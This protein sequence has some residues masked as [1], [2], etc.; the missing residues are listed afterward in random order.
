MGGWPRHH[1]DQYA[2]RAHG[3]SGRYRARPAA[4]HGARIPPGRALSAFRPVAAG[5]LSPEQG[6]LARPHGRARRYGPHRAGDRAPARRHARA[7][8]LS[9]APACSGHSLPALSEPV[10][11]GAAGGSPA[12]HYAGR[13]ADQKSHQ[14]RGARCAGQTRHPH[15]HGPRVSGGRAGADQGA[16]GRGPFCPPASTS[17]HG[18]RMCRRS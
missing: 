6:H 9:F 1:G 10:G 4:V 15:Q 7:G 3:R 2:R 17:M 5:G 16:A 14:R 8:G 12:G 18:S 11:H 13:G